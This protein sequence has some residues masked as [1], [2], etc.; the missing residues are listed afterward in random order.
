MAWSDERFRDTARAA[1]A[2]RSA[3]ELLPENYGAWMVLG[4][5]QYRS[6]EWADARTTLLKAIEL[7]GS[8]NHFHASCF[9]AMTYWQLGE[10]ETARQHYDHAAKVFEKIHSDSETKLGFRDEAAELLGIKS[11]EED[12]AENTA[13]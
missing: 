11:D 8:N 10:K 7:N 2:E 5:A 3:M 13:D 9:L 1:A 12:A 6:G 4:M